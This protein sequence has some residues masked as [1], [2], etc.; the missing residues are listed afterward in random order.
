M[1]CTRN[2]H[3]VTTTLGL[4]SFIVCPRTCATTTNA[5]TRALLPVDNCFD[6]DKPETI[7]VEFSPALKRKGSDFLHT[8]LGHMPKSSLMYLAKDGCAEGKMIS[9]WP[10]IIT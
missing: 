7:C 9:N 2:Y 8:S 5:T 1:G 6:A 4:L 3:Q 10:K